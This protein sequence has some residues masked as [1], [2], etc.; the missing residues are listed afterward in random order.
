MLHPRYINAVLALF[1]AVFYAAHGVW[2]GL[3]LLG[4]TGY[5]GIAHIFG[6]VI[7][8]ILIVHA[9]ISLLLVFVFDGRNRP[10]IYPRSN[11][12]VYLQRITGIIVIVLVYLHITFY[13]APFSGPMNILMVVLLGI[14]I[15]V[16]LPRAA[17]TLGL[18]GS[19]S[20]MKIFQAASWAASILIM[21]VTILGFWGA[22]Y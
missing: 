6:M 8:T 7:F 4:F 20:G 1:L 12:A 10:V 16:S 13:N 11:A 21:I 19:D 22:Y 3:F 5:S 14:H 15:G 17:V 18:V 2:E 9:V